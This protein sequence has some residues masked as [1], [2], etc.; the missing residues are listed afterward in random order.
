MKADFFF[1][2]FADGYSFW[3]E[4]VNPP[5]YRRMIDNFL[6]DHIDIALDAGCGPGHLSLF[7]AGHARAV[8]GLDISPRM[9][10]IARQKQ[11]AQA[12]PNLS[13]SVADLHH[14]PF[15]ASTFD[16]IASDSVLH[17]TEVARTLPALI[18]LLRPGG[19]LIIRDLVTP[20]PGRARSPLWQ[21]MRTIKNTP[22]YVRRLGVKDTVRL[23][24][25]ELRPEWIVHKCEGANMTPKTFREIYSRFLPGCRFL[26]FGWS[27]TALWKAPVIK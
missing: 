7:L 20:N 21:I 10:Q 16:L 3:I 12:V 17:D 15:A 27:V 18:T 14:P 25:F 1:N 2:D 22:R 26:D 9:V 11:V 8:I 24:S 19:H 5:N 23:L 4:Q 6:P 13:F